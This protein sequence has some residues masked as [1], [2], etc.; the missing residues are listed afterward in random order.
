MTRGTLATQ[1]SSATTH[2]AFSTVGGVAARRLRRHT[3]YAGAPRYGGAG[4][5]THPGRAGLFTARPLDPARCQL[6][7]GVASCALPPVI[8]NIID[9]S[10]GGVLQGAGAYGAPCTQDHVIDHEE[11]VERPSTA[12]TAG[13]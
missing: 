4:D 5:F 10:Y 11:K 7:Y 3:A 13:C 2:T 8:P 12:M 9:P 6:G 1:P